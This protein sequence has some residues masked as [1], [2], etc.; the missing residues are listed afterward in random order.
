MTTT[1]VTGILSFL[2]GVA[3]GTYPDKA[4]AVG[5]WTWDRIKAGGRWAGT[6]L[7]IV[8]PPAGG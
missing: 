4:K 5:S 1:I 6:R 3:C 8:K 7:G 2:L